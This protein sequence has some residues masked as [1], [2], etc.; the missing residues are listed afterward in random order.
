M[1]VDEVKAQVLIGKE[2]QDFLESDLGKVILGMA[3]Q[4]MESAVEG[5]SSANAANT[6]QVIEAQV[7]VRVAM[8]F[9]RYLVELI[10]RGSEVFEAYKQQKQES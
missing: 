10:T 4:D 7:R 8:R 2:A 1:T 6:E 9:E 5:F 3:K